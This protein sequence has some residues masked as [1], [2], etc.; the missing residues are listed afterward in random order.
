MLFGADEILVCARDLVN[1][2]SVRARPG[3]DVTYVHLLFDRHQIVRSANL[4]TES[5]LPGPQTRSSFE[6]SM[7]EEILSLFPDID[8]DTGLGYAPAARRILKRYEAQ[9]LRHQQVA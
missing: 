1:D 5:F 8:P 9:V 3:G 4:E 2:R 7:V 6:A